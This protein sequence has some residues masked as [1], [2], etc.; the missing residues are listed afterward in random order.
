MCQT[1]EN[2]ARMVKWDEKSRQAVTMQMD[3]R[4]WKGLL[5]PLLEGTAWCRERCVF[6][7]KWTWAGRLRSDIT[8]RLRQVEGVVW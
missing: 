2:V 4:R 5:E 6:V 1:V 3:M 7:G 8:G